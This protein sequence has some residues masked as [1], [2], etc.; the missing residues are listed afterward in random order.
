MYLPL[1]DIE[2]KHQFFTSGMHRTFTVSPT[3][4]TEA[5]AAE[6]GLSSRQTPDGIRVFYESRRLKELQG[7]AG[8]PET[9]LQLGFKLD[10]PDHLFAR[11]T[12][13]SC[14]DDNLFYFDQRCAREESAER[15][16][17]HRDAQ[18]SEH[19]VEPLQSPR[20]DD[21]LEPTE[22]AAPPLG[23]I[24]IP[25]APSD[26]LRTYDIRFAARKT[27]WTYYLLGR[28]S[29]DGL[30]MEDA[31]GETEFDSLGEV[32]LPGGRV[33]RAFR[34]TSM[35]PL[36]D[37]YHNRFQIIDPDAAGDR[38]MMARMPGAEVRQTYQE[39]CNGTEVAVSEIFINGG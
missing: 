10:T 22:Q 31:K 32:T 39:R 2:V 6:L 11:Y 35:L 12:E 18:V 7:D 36:Q 13:P 20:I 25:L 30:Y 34:T 3:V 14:P 29:R 17:L 15:S 8:N 21:L 26:G 27:F 16:R 24:R 4:R 38:V 37:R 5:L 23:V 33:A 19:E 9:P 28:F 1:F